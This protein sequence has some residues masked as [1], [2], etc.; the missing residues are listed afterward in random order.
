[1]K[2]LLCTALAMLLLTAC[3]AGD[4]GTAAPSA[5]PTPA[6]TP[7]PT[8]SPAAEPTAAPDLP[9][10]FA[11]VTGA[12][13]AYDDIRP[14]VQQGL[15]P[16][17]MV[18]GYF[19]V[20]QDGLWGLM[21]ADGTEVLPCAATAPVRRCEQGHWM[22]DTPLVVGE[23][24]EQTDAVLQQN[25]DGSLEP[26]HGGWIGQFF[27]DLTRGE[28]CLYHG[29]DGRFFFTPVGTPDLLP[30]T[31]AERL[32][33][34]AALLPLADRREQED[35]FAGTVPGEAES[36]LYYY[37]TAAGTKV[38]V[39]T[40][41]PVTAAGFFYDEALAPVRLGE[42][43][44]AYIDRSGALVTEAVYAPVFDEAYAYND[45]L[46]IWRA[47]EPMMAAPLR[48]G[49]AAVRR[50]DTGGWGLLDAAGAEAVP[51]VYAGCVWDGTVLWLRPDAQS[52]WQAYT[53]AA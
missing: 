1:M 4:T 41:E 14:V 25:G 46:G 29:M 16:P 31:C 7:A 40:E 28:P 6:P 34:A 22:W 44:W 36:D 24:R 47:A 30:E 38:T 37:D 27:F 48:G 35:E 15:D 42:G 17:D 23:E 49:Y 39:Q 18:R 45:A 8:A 52:P 43:N 12:T 13:L 9:Q 20:C 33:P 3:G 32:D 51:A 11:A 5:T 26:G 50:A 10:G 21:R 19:T 53:P 2:R